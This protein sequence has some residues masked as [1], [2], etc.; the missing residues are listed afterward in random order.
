MGGAVPLGSIPVAVTSI[1]SSVQ[2]GEVPA[3]SPPGTQFS[4]T[5]P[6][7]LQVA[8]GGVGFAVSTWVVPF[9]LPWAIS[10]AARFAWHLAS[11]AGCQL[12][13]FGHFISV[14]GQTFLTL[15]HVAT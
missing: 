7:E 8:A 2:S 4:R 13:Q 12:P 6:P 5:D 3:G 15:P 9:H 10:M 1:P 14:W 11:W